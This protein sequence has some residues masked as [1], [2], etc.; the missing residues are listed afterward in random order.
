MTEVGTRS[1]KRSSCG[2]AATAAGFRSTD[3][4][5]SG[6]FIVV[7]GRKERAIIDWQVH[8]AHREGGTSWLI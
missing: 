6:R 5:G 2:I 4:D 3:T 1:R 7:D 8:Q